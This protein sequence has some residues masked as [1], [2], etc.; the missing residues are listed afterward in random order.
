MFV[1]AGLRPFL[2]LPAALSAKRGQVYSYLLP[3]VSADAVSCHMMK[4]F[5]AQLTL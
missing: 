1:P 2:K 3:A 5:A 4:R